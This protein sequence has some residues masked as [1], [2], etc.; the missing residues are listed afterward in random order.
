MLPELENT[1]L[2]VMPVDVAGEW[3]TA[4][5]RIW[6]GRA[7]A[8]KPLV[9]VMMC[10]TDSIVWAKTEHPQMDGSQRVQLLLSNLDRHGCEVQVN[11][12]VGGNHARARTRVE[13]A[14]YRPNLPTRLQVRTGNV[15]KLCTVEGDQ[16]VEFWVIFLCSDDVEFSESNQWTVVSRLETE[17]VEPY[18]AVLA[19]GRFGE[20]ALQVGDEA[21]P[22]NT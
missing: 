21:E 17:I 9:A 3:D 13:S 20:F 11:C 10:V 12:G 6:R 18:R 1:P 16:S 4:D 15:E 7:H 8:D 19:G 14:A 2:Q 22:A 5:K